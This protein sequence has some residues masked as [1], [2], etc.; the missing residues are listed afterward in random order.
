MPSVIYAECCLVFMLS[1][2]I[3]NVIMMGVV[4]LN[5]VAPLR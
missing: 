1:V 4:M 3:L 5:A 2:A